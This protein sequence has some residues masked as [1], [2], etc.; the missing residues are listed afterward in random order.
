MSESAGFDVSK[1]ETSFCVKDALGRV[2]AHG[3][4]ET[5]ALF[6]AVS[7]HCRDVGRVV[8]G[9]GALSGRLRRG[10]RELARVDAI[11]ARR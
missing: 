10:L 7:T 4:T 3:K 1:E 2:L 8:P 6:S 5:E 9:T 11:D